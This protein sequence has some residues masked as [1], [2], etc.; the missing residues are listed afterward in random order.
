MGGVIYSQ[1]VYVRSGRLRQRHSRQVMEKLFKNTFSGAG[2]EVRAE[3]T[4][5]STN[6]LSV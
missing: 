6:S 3:L 4:R 1:L 5:L 2:D